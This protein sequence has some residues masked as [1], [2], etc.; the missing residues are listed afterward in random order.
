MF[1]GSEKKRI[2]SYRKRKPGS[3]LKN[4]T[5]GVLS[6]QGDDGYPYGGPMNY[7]YGDDMQSISTVQRE[8][9]KMEGFRRS[10]RF[11]SVLWGKMR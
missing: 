8:G 1:R 2:S 10:I 4:G 6:V 5:H 7:V 3:I 11:P 9:H